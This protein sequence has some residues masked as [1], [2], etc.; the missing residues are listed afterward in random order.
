MRGLKVQ[1]FHIA[2]K[3]YFVRISNLIR[4]IN[5]IVLLHLLVFT[6]DAKEVMSPEYFGNC[7]QWLQLEFDNCPH[8]FN[9]FETHK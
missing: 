2:K 1:I 9:E 8:E 7:S 3:M 5:T 4:I 6:P